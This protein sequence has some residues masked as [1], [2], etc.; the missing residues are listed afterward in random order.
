M[1]KTTQDFVDPLLKNNQDFKS[2]EEFHIDA[3]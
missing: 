3:G 2:H 1:E